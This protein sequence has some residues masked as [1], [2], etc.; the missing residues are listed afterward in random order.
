MVAVKARIVSEWSE[1]FNS[2]YR[3]TEIY[4]YVVGIH[5]FLS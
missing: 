1:N 5:V 2:K 3:Q 4:G